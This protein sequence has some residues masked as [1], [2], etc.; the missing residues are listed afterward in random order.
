MPGQG[1]SSDGSDTLI[2]FDSRTGALT[3]AEGSPLKVTRWGHTCTTLQDGTVLVTGGVNEDMGSQRVLQDAWIYTP[4][5][6]Q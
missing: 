6:G 1:P 3:P 5:P 4:I 2:T